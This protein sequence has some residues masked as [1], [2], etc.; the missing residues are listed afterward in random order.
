MYV[1]RPY[2]TWHSGLFQAPRTQEVNTELVPACGN[3][4]LQDV[5]VISPFFA[6]IS[7]DRPPASP[8]FAVSSSPPRAPNLFTDAREER[9]IMPPLMDGRRRR[10]R[11]RRR[12]NAART[13][14]TLL[15]PFD[16][17]LPFQ[18]NR[19]FVRRI[20]FF[21]LFS[22]SLL[23]TSFLLS[24]ARRETCC[25][26]THTFRVTTKRETIRSRFSRSKRNESDRSKD[27][28]RIRDFFVPYTFTY[29]K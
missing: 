2:R 8:P 27:I 1:A 22:L 13:R 24:S 23:Q 11:R 6:C 19:N 18:T 28:S 29:E 25:I 20:L 14:P 10:R 16:P 4:R 9:F 15:D 7:V 21:L 12:E 26:H 17:R 3:R 5:Y